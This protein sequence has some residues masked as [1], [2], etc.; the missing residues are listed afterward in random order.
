MIT[1]EEPNY[2]HY[3]RLNT[4]FADEAQK[5]LASFELRGKNISDPD[6]YNIS[7][8]EEMKLASEVLFSAF[9]SNG[10]KFTSEVNP[11]E[12]DNYDQQYYNLRVIELNLSDFCTWA[13]KKKYKLPEELAVLSTLP[14]CEVVKTDPD[15]EGVNDTKT[16]SKGKKTVVPATDNTK[17]VDGLLKMVIAM[18]MDC[19][20]YDPAELK[21][22]TTADIM[23]A[24]SKCG[25]SVSE[26]T[27][28]ERLRQAQLLLPRD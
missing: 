18:A 23:N 17:T 22:T 13:S 1:V 3:S 19:Y 9:D 11:C 5:L 4:I 15:K 14:D 7:L 26:N 25:L 27:I 24:L 12:Y 28:R 8:K 20:G 2:N 6:E 21:S 10:L 16:E